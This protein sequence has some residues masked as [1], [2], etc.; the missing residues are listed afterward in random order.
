MRDRIQDIINECIELMKTGVS[1]EDCLG[2]YPEYVR[3]LEPILSSVTEVSNNF[4]FDL[5]DNART[6]IRARVMSNWDHRHVSV[7]RRWR[8]P[9]FLPKWAGV[10]VS[11]LLAFLLGG[12]GTVAASGG[13]VPGGLLYPVKQ[14]REETQLWFSLSPEAKVYLYS[15]LVNERVEELTML[16]TAEDTHSG[17]ISV[18][19]LEQHVNSLNQLIVNHESQLADAITTVEASLSEAESAAKPTQTFNRL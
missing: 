4:R 8:M 16:A 2:R 10:A 9:F 18:D 15:N 12:V 6:R 13:A 11:L 1:L 17:S 5:P 3:E 7:G 14:M 19:R